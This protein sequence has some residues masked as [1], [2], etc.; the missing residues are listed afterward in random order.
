MLIEKDEFEL[1]ET[2]ILS[3]QIEQHEVPK[4]LAENPEFEAWYKRRHLAN[5]PSLSLLPAVGE[6]MLIRNATMADSQHLFDW[7]NDPLT[8]SMSKSREPVPWDQHINWLTMRLV[9]QQPGLFIAELT[10]PVGTLRIDGD[11]ISYTVA[12]AYRGQGLGY[13]MLKAASLRFGQFRAEIYRRNLPSIKIA[14]RAGM[15]VVI[16]DD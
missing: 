4:L 16:L 7:R 10:E 1:Y 15:L 8:R 12:P 6:T 5:A 9:R 11:E 14:E 3:G 13:R 2:C